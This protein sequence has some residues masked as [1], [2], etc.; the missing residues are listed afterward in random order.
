MALIIILFVIAF[1]YSIVSIGMTLIYF[2]ELKY[3][4]I[5]FKE[6]LNCSIMPQQFP[7]LY[8]QFGQW[9]F[10][11]SGFVYFEYD[12]GFRLNYNNIHLLGGF[13]AFVM[14]IH[15][16]WRLKFIKEAKRKIKS[17]ELK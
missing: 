12:E 15:N 16:Y 1:F 4:R 2:K 17:L 8:K 10:S 3:C 6:F 14:P 5:S 11:D 13:I 9:C 7:D